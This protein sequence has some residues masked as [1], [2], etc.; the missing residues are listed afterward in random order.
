M[1]ALCFLAAG[2][3]AIATTAMAQPV[4]NVG[5]VVNGASYLPGIAPGSIF[6]IKGSGLGPATIIV[7]SS[8]PYPATLSNTS[9]TFTPVSGGAAISALMVYTLNIQL[10]ALLPSSAAPGDYNVTVMY[11]GL[12]SAPVAAK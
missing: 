6:V 12:T 5:G 4:I 1:K 2:V 11:N 8:L 7:Q 9:I 10:A 3:F